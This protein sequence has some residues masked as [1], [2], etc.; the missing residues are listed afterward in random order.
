MSIIDKIVING[1]TY[2]IGG[3]GDGLT[4]D[5]KAALDQVAAKVAYI[6][7]DGGDYYSALHSALYP[8]ANLSYI[9]CVYTQSGTVYDTASLNS[10]KSDLVV[11][12]H[13]T[14]STTGTVTD[15]TLT[16]TLTVGT[17]TITV[18]YGGKT[19]TF[20]VTVTEKQQS[21]A[22]PLPNVSYDSGSGENTLSITNGNHITGF[23]TSN[24]RQYFVYEDAS[25]GT[26]HSQNK[27][28]M[29]SV[30]ANDTYELKIKNISWSGN[31]AA[32]N[33]VQVGMFVKG[34]QNAYIFDEQIDLATSSQASGTTSDV[35]RTGTISSS[36]AV[37]AFR[38]L[39]YRSQ[40]FTFDVELKINGIR[41]I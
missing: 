31:S 41:Y 34:T 33:Y 7:D 8:P 15:Y 24:S 20:T 28:E 14:N 12:A 27:D 1:T 22:Y 18:T 36:V 3:S 29:F 25:V 4:S 11:T 5:V 19:T 39:S 2:D 23:S 40:T 10:L 37:N 26:Y 13:Y 16:G 6:D 30:S 17:S 9:T 38:V 32:T 21:A 35:T